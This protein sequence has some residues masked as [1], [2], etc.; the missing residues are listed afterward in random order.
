MANKLL[1]ARF[2]KTF[3]RARDA[4]VLFGETKRIIARSTTVQRIPFKTKPATAEEMQALDDVLK[5]YKLDTD[6]MQ[7]LAKSI[8]TAKGPLQSLRIA[9]LGSETL[10]KR[11]GRAMI[12]FYRGLLLASAKTHVTN[13]VSGTVETLVTPVGTVND[14]LQIVPCAGLVP[15]VEVVGSDTEVTPKFAGFGVSAA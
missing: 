14:A 7:I 12:E 10:A 9:E 13:I 3:E 6:G 5:A 8:E 11:G 2:I 1:R 15:A 4:E